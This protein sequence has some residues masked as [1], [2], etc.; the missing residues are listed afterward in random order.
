MK[1]TIN[2][3]NQPK[4]GFFSDHKSQPKRLG[5]WKILPTHTLTPRVLRFN[6]F[7]HLGLIRDLTNARK[8]FKTFNN[9][10]MQNKH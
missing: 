2:F 10:K 3:R 6:D 5:E 4:V 8:E 9:P 1:E 7:R